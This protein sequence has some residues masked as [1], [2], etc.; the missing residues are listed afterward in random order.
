M[1]GL[2]GVLG[3]AL[4]ALCAARFAAAS[5]T[6][7]GKLSSL[8]AVPDGAW[9]CPPCGGRMESLRGMVGDAIGD[10]FDWQTPRG[11]PWYEPETTAGHIREL[12]PWRYELAE[13]ATCV[14]M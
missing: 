10:E 7:A 5:S 9:F 1:V 6:S 13:G 2:L 3:S 11:M 12:P 14:D 4:S 8:T